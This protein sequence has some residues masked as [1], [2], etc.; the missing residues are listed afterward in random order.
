V[1]RILKDKIVGFLKQGMTPRGLALAVA[2]GLVLGT[3][4][5][6]GATTLLCIAASL[7]LRLNLP[8]MQSVNWVASPL[9]LIL[10]I[11]FFNLGGVL[12]GGGHVAVSLG[13]LIGMMNTDLLGTIREF[14]FVTLRAVCA[15]ILVAPLATGLIYI[16]LLPLFTRLQEEFVRLRLE[17]KPVRFDDVQ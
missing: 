2:I 15:W 9:Q 1:R 12:F 7:V 10:L 6:I 8:A 5:V 16:L 14:L 11:P 13:D 17:P 4:P 3:F